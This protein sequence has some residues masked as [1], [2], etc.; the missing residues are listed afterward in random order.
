MVRVFLINSVK[1]RFLMLESRK[2][3]R[4]LV[5]YALKRKIS[6]KTGTFKFALLRKNHVKRSKKYGTLCGRLE[7][8]LRSGTLRYSTLKW[9]NSDPL[10]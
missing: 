3:V 8:S 6:V 9:I 1:L 7:R 2:T 4:V 5:Q 10:L